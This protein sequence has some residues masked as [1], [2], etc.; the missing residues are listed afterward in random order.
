[1]LKKILCPLPG[2]SRSLSTVAESNKRNAKTEEENFISP[3]FNHS[4]KNSR[5]FPQA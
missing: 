5:K 2:I 1:M 3:F 4:K